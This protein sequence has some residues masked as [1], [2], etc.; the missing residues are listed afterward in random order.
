MSFLFR[1]ANC[2]MCVLHHCV[3]MT[4]FFEQI[5]SSCPVLSGI[6]KIVYKVDH[7]AKREF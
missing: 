7:F 6:G 4:L 5:G 2:E 3:L 1:G